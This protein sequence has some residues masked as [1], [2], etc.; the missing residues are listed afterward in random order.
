[1]WSKDGR[2]LRF[3]QFGDRGTPEATTSRLM[4]IASGGGIPEFMGLRLKGPA[5]VATDDMNPDDTRIG[6]ATREEAV[7]QVW[8]LSNVLSVLAP[9]P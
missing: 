3:S 4:R 8:E 1:M 9:A 7:G 2:Y 6:F 5:T